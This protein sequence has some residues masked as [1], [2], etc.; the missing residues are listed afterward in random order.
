MAPLNDTDLPWMDTED[1][2]MVVHAMTPEKIFYNDL[3]EAAQKKWAA[4][5]K[6]FSYKVHV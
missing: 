3:D 1:N 2:K 6:P 4:Q 5:L